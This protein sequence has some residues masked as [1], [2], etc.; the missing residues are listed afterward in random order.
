[1]IKTLRPFLDKNLSCDNFLTIPDEEFF[2]NR[3]SSNKTIRSKFGKQIDF[4]YLCMYYLRILSNAIRHG[5]EVKKERK[6]PSG[7]SIVIDTVNGTSGTLKGFIIH[8]QLDS[9][10]NYYLAILRLAE[11]GL[12]QQAHCL[13]RTTDE[14]SWLLMVLLYDN[15]KFNLY[16]KL[17]EDL[18]KKERLKV[19]FGNFTPAILLK[20]IREMDDSLLHFGT[21]VYD[22]LER[23][24]NRNT[25]YV[26]N[27]LLACTLGSHGSP[28]DTDDELVPLL[29]GTLTRDV[30]DIIDH[31]NYTML[32]FIK[33]FTFLL[34][35]H[36]TVKKG[37]YAIIE[38]IY[39][40]VQQCS[41]VLQADTSI[42]ELEH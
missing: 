35:R 15:N 34:S 10:I 25:D 16:R 33:A 37:K 20:T 22:Y 3:I 4:S 1:V 42:E 38:A 13:L 18:P 7:P 21:D 17:G 12:T 28:F 14:L 26:H 5:T 11:D 41:I 8:N 36:C 39:A 6:K 31:S 23:A 27:S 32:Y 30:K 2:Q 40:C 19:W 24:K 29:M 9:L